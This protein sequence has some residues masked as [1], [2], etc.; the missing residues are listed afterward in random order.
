MARI[1]PNFLLTP[2]QMN[3]IEFSY[4]L[5]PRSLGLCLIFNIT[6]FDRSTRQKERSGSNLDAERVHRIFSKM[7][8]KCSRFNDVR[9]QDIINACTDVSKRP[10]LKNHSSLVVIILSHG[11]EDAIYARDGLIPVDTIVTYFKGDNCAALR[12]KPK[13]FFI[14]SCRGTRV[15]EGVTLTTEAAYQGS[16]IAVRKI[17]VEADILIH[18]STVPGYFAWR[19][20]TKG[21]WF[22]QKLCD[23]LERHSD[24]NLDLIE[25]LTIVNRHVAYLCYSKTDNEVTD[26]MKQMPSII[27]QLTRRVKL[28]SWRMI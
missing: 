7:G 12:G 25:L 20:E 2:E 3:S 21:S 10:D 1:D 23:V 8:Y 26:D 11:E 22:I 6:E 28:P 18:H 5:N 13:L 15:D 16:L 17:P 24:R 9:K 27:N 4:D 14:Q 19:N